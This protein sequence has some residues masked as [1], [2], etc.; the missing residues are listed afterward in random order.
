[1]AAF[2]EELAAQTLSFEEA[3]HLSSEAQAY[4]RMLVTLSLRDPAGEHR[5][6]AH[7]GGGSLTLVLELNSLF[8]RPAAIRFRAVE[9]LAARELYLLLTY[10]EAEMFTSSYRGVFDRLLARM[11]QEG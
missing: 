8:E 11:R 9:H 1:M 7:P 6:I 5:A 10:G 4:F 3:A 2:V